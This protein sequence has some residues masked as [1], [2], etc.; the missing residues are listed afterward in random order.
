MGRVQRSLLLQP[1]NGGSRFVFR[2]KRTNR[3]GLTS[4]ALCQN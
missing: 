3:L 4:R 2:P 1:D